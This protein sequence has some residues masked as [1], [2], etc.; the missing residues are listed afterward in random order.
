M[1]D[2]HS[3]PLEVRED[4]VDPRQQDMRRHRAHRLRQVL[5]PLHSL[6]RREA[7]GQDR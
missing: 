4:P 7:V 2:A 1:V 6:I 3:E 5:A